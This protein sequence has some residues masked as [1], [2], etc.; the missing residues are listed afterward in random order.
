MMSS[1]IIK[2]IFTDLES[3][4][5]RVADVGQDLHWLFKHDP[6]GGRCPV[7]TEPCV[8]LTE[9]DALVTLNDL[10]GKLI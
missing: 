4:T 3:G 8:V 2:K 10:Q 6:E 1:C 9:R 7:T 5:C